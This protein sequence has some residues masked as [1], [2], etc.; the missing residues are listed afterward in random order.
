[1]DE[2]EEFGLKYIIFNNVKNEEYVVKY[3]KTIFI[4]IY[5][6]LIISFWF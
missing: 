5:L 6:T 4:Y 3:L 2:I 1:M